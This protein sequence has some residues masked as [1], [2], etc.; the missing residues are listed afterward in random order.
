MIR[1]LLTSAFV[2]GCAS[3]MAAQSAAAEPAQL[4][5]AAEKSLALLQSCGPTFFVK[6]G[7]IACHQQSVTSLALGEARKRALK[8]DEKT[9]REQVY[10]TVQF[11]KTTRERFLERSDTP[12][13]SAPSVGYIAWGLGAENYPP[14]EITDAMIIELAGRQQPDG[15]WTAFGHRPPLEYSRI[16]ATALAIRALQ[17]YG[18]PSLKASMEKNIERGT[19]WLVASQ[20]ASTSDHVFR[21]L[22]LVWARRNAAEVKAEASW[23]LKAQNKDGGWSEQPTLDTDGYATGITLYGLLAAGQIASN[24]DACQRAVDFLLRTQLPDGSWY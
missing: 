3:F 7:C 17:L 5:A 10:V 14:D 21:M 20:P 8:V 1:R 18:P 2:L 12:A 9:A 15:S 13:G 4:K 22:G 23:I 24:D 19:G 11:A 16:S 6:S